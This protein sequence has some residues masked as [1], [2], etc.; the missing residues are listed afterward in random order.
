MEIL[1]V[2]VPI[3]IGFVFVM[4]MAGSILHFLAFGSIFSLIRKKMQEQ[5]EAAAPRQCAYCG[6]TTLQGEPKCP[7]CGASR[8]FTAK[9]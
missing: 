6:A 2:V 5:Q 7:S 9:H 1:F 3:F 4:V 8:D